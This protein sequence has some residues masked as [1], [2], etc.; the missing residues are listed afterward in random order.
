MNRIAQL[1]IG[2]TEAED[3]TTLETAIEVNLWKIHD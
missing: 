2:H 3:P 1:D